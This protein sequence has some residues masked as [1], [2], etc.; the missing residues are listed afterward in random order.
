MIFICR[1]VEYFLY[2]GFSDNTGKIAESILDI[3]QLAVHAYN[4]KFAFHIRRNHF[5][6]P[7]GRNTKEPGGLPRRSWQLPWRYLG[8][9]SAPWKTGAT[10]PLFCWSLSSPVTFRCPLKIFLSM[11]RVAVQP[12]VKLLSRRIHDE[13]KKEIKEL[14]ANIIPDKAS[15]KNILWTSS[16]KSVA[17]VEE[18]HGKITVTGKDIGECEIYA[19]S[20]DNKEIKAVCKI[21]CVFDEENK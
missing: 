12:A 19:I 7:T 17:V 16:D 1:Y 13:P 10:I 15:F 3:T 21:T 11:R 18:K 5:E 20:L 8:R 4:V 14:S 2:G 6:K 9:P